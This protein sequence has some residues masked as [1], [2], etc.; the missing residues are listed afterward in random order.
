MP[1]AQYYGVF[2]VIGFVQILPVHQA[3]PWVAGKGELKGG[4]SNYTLPASG[5]FFNALFFGDADV[6]LC[7]F[8]KHNSDLI[9]VIDHIVGPSN[10][11]VLVRCGVGDLLLRMANNTVG[12]EEGYTVTFFGKGEEPV[13]EVVPCSFANEGDLSRR[14]IDGV[15]HRV[16]GFRLR[17]DGVEVF[18]KILLLAAYGC[19]AHDGEEGH[20]SDCFSHDVLF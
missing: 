18:N 2:C 7:V 11:L 4:T 6:F 17:G 9:T 5:L 15:A 16:G 10:G 1:A 13:E 8:I 12:L 14:A 20:G 19:Q 3:A